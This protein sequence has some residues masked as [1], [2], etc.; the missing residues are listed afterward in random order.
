M[1]LFLGGRDEIHNLE[2]VDMDVYWSI[3][4]QLR[5]GTRKLPEGT[6][7]QQVSYES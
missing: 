7:I 3:C 2:L 6:T 4:G 1:P 5:L